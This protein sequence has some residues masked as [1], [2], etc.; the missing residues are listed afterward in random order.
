M[1]FTQAVNDHMVDLQVVG[2]LDEVFEKAGLLKA[3]GKVGWELCEELEGFSK[4]DVQ[5]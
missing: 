1:L 2:Q 4:R 5:T 3:T